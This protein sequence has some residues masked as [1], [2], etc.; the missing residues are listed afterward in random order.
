LLG[1]AELILVKS[2]KMLVQRNY[3]LSNLSGETPGRHHLQQGKT[4]QL[5]PMPLVP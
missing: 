2:G 5:Y 4:S 1:T 3:I